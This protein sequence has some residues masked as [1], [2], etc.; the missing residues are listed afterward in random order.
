MAK[1]Y[2]LACIY[3]LYS[4]Y[5]LLDLRIRWGEDLFM[6]CLALRAPPFS[7]LFE[8][9]ILWYY[10]LFYNKYDEVEDDVDMELNSYATVQPFLVV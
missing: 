2:S 5:L 4:F 7:F 8:I 1:K 3:H 10:Y 9:A 6:S